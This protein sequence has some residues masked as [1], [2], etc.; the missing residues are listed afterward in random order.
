MPPMVQRFEVDGSGPKRSPN[1]LAAAC[2]A[3]WTTPGSTVAVRSCGSMSM[4]R[5]RCRF[6][7]MTRPGPTALPAQLVPAPRPVIGMPASMAAATTCSSS[8]VLRG[9]ATA[10]GTMR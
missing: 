3:D 1:G 9:L 10:R 7:S 5:R 2:S 6:M 4:M 8:S